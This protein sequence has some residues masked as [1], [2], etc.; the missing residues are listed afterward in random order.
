MKRSILARHGLIAAAIA[1]GVSS[2]AADN[3]C[4]MKTLRGTYVFTATGYNL[5]SGVAQPKAIVELITFN[6]D[7]TLSVPAATRS[8]NG[9]IGRSPAGG[10]GTYT[11][12]AGCTGTIAFSNGPTFD[13]F[14]SPNDP[15]LWMIQTDS[16]TVFEGTTLRTA[17]QPCS[18]ATLQGAYGV[19]LNGT[20][21]ATFVKPGGRGAPGLLENVIGTVIQIFDGDGNLTQVDNVQGSI[22]GIVPDRPGR[23][24][25]AV[26]SDCALTQTVTPPG[27]ASIITKG[28][29]VDSG[30]E[31]RQ[32]TVSPEG[33]F[34]VAIGR[35]MN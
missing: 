10:T 3:N 15:K 29:V 18:N 17:G 30:R 22:A 13:I 25:Y 11:V 2:L 20:R 1:V 26:N 16:N 35:K 8:V 21:P 27:Q 9:V 12:D 6:G 32:N 14:V 19:Q 28:V 24:T 4:T 7:G 33:F 5:V 34:I 31:F 23:G